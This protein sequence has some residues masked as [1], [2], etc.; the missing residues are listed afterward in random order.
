[1]NNQKLKRVYTP[2]KME[3][4]QIKHQKALMEYSGTISLHEFE[5]H[6]KA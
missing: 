1:M 6:Y 5:K 3:I 2:P 4:V